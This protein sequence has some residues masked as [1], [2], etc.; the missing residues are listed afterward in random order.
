[1]R[2]L[3]AGEALQM[4]HRAA[5]AEHAL[6]DVCARDNDAPIIEGASAGF[7]EGAWK[8]TMLQLQAERRSISEAVVQGQHDIRAECTAALRQYADR[9][10]DRFKRCELVGC[11]VPVR[12][13]AAG[14]R[15]A[16]HVDLCF[17]DPAGVFHGARGAFVVWDYKFREDAP[18][19]AF[20]ARNLQFGL[21]WLCAMRGQYLVSEQ[22]QHW[23]TPAPEAGRTPCVTA[24]VHMPYLKPFGRATTYK[25]DDG[26]EVQ[27][28][29]GDRRPDRMILRECGLRKANADAVLADI[30]Q[31]VELLRSGIDLA[32][33]EELGCHL[34]ECEPWCRRHDDATDR[35]HDTKG[36]DQ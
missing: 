29:K 22:M 26:Q 25:D 21:Y 28:K 27:A 30:M 13:E 3:V 32:I 36:P 10:G 2:G 16:S 23:V 7:V 14:V 18:T 5:D 24:W 15:F 8:S 6:W 31:H 20:L 17:Y 9:F 19:R 34:C 35:H 33:P 4:L 12:M 11:E 1:M